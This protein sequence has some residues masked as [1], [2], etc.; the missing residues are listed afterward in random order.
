M[1]VTVSDTR[2]LASDKSGQRAADL[3]NELGFADRIDP[4]FVAMHA[5]ETAGSCDAKKAAIAKIRSLH[6]PR[7]LPALR[8]VL[9][10]G[11]GGWFKSSCYRDE[12]KA[13]IAEIER[14]SPR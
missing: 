8:A 13:A 4:Y 7:T 10:K 9:G 5:I 2:A 14:T 12:A 3:L 1:V 11:I 6:D